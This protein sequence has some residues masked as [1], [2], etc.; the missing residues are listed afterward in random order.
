MQDSGDRSIYRNSIMKHIHLLA[1]LIALNLCDLVSPSPRACSADEPVSFA[2]EVLPILSA[3]CFACHGPDEAHREAD[4]RLDQ[5]QDA[6]A[7]RG[8]AT[9]IVPGQSDQS[10]IIQRITS[11]DPDLV[12]PPPSANHAVSPE[13]LETLR[14]WIDQGATWQL[15]WSFQPITQPGGNIDYWIKQGVRPRL[16]QRQHPADS[17]ETIETESTVAAEPFAPKAAPQS[18]LRRLSLDLIGLPPT[19]KMPTRSP[20]T[21]QLKLMKRV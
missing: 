17:Q 6:K 2:K 8:E 21:Q 11:D 15:H 3:K 13:Q 4:L 14:R 5:E 16:E 12:M 20:Q 7:D 19:P 9:A 1:T 18:L 10:A